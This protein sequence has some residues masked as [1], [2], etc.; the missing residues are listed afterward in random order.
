LRNWFFASPGISPRRVPF[1]NAR[2]R[3]TRLA[4]TTLDSLQASAPPT[5][6]PVIPTF[7]RTMDGCA[8]RRNR[9]SSSPLRLAALVIG[10]AAQCGVEKRE[11]RSCPQRAFTAPV[12]GRTR[13]PPRQRRAAP[14]QT[15]PSVATAAER[16]ERRSTEAL[17]CAASPARS[18]T[19]DRRVGGMARRQC[20]RPAER[21]GPVGSGAARIAGE[22][23]GDSVPEPDH[24]TPLV[25]RRGLRVF[26][27]SADT[28]HRLLP[29]EEATRSHAPIWNFR[30]I[31]FWRKIEQ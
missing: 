22:S 21:D 14:A 23:A 30:G 25:T 6:P 5:L 17:A 4:A 19:F 7:V 24:P 9:S 8:L 20:V 13:H 10:D 29:V 12:G 26:G 16:V 18:L 11:S 27:F 31:A 1:A 15:K 2:L 3:P 28:G